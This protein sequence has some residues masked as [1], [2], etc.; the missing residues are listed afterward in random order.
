MRDW[1]C[2]RKSDIQVV[3]GSIFYVNIVDYFCLC[4][5][6]LKMVK[7]IDSC[8]FNCLKFY[9]LLRMFFLGLKKVYYSKDFLSLSMS[10]LNYNFVS[11]LCLKYY[12][13]NDLWDY[14]RST[15]SF[16]KIKEILLI[17]KFCFKK[18][19]FYLDIFMYL[20]SDLFINS[21]FY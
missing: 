7:I 20:E 11:Q 21:Y 19:T 17:Y 10:L 12:T 3:E 8:L 2:H 18:V 16:T 1:I 13:L 5:T 4:F 15:N 9:L 14:V 6:S